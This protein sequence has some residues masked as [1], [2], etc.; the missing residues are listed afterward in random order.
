VGV[1]L[2]RCV[3]KAVGNELGSKVGDLELALVGT[4]V[5]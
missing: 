4:M 2:G 1:G 3:G 5:G